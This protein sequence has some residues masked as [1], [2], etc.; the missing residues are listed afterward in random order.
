M[1][2]CNGRHFH[3]S[4]GVCCSAYWMLI[5][6]TTWS[7]CT[8]TCLYITDFTAKMPFSVATFCTL[9]NV[10]ALLSHI[11]QV[12]ANQ[13]LCFSPIYVSMCLGHATYITVLDNSRC[14]IQLLCMGGGRKKQEN[15]P[16]NSSP[17]SKVSLHC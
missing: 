2:L 17:S 10:R 1:D 8:R 4:G 15:Q 12:K 13:F 16:V 7:P 3:C 14:Y 11:V 9:I 5:C 6:C